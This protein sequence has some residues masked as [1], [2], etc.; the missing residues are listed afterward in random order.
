MMKK[1]TM[2]GL[3]MIKEIMG[4]NVLKITAYIDGK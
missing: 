2:E 1:F 4:L 3:Y